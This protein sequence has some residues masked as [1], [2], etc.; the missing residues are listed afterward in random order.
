MSV[1]LLPIGL[2]SLAV[3]VGLLVGGRLFASRF[4]LSGDVRRSLR[5]GTGVIAAI[6]L[7]TGLALVAVGIVSSG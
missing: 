5:L 3:G 7:V 6:L 4:D 2:G 1:G